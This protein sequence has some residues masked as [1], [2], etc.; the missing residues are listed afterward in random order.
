M[1][2]GLSKLCRVTKL[3]DP[4]KLCQQFGMVAGKMVDHAHVLRQA[5]Q[6]TGRQNQIEVVHAV[7]L[8]DHAKLAIDVGRPAL[9]MLDLLVAETP[10]VL[11]LSRV[12][13]GNPHGRKRHS[14]F[15]CASDTARP[16][17]GA[18]KAAE[19]KSKFNP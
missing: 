17:G 14:R 12:R 4:L 13:D 19:Q 3:H 1:A 18:Q 10:G 2:F 16:E 5:G 11:A 8:L 9:H 15:R 6:I 7:A